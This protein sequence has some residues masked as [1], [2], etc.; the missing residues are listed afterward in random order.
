MVYRYV[1][2]GTIE[3]KV[4]ALQRRKRDLFDRVVDDGGAMSGAITADDIRALLDA[5]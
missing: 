4:V 1:S 2:A 5:D 3:E